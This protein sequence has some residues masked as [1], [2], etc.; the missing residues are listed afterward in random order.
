[1]NI[2]P[3][4]SVIITTHN[5]L[6]FLKRA[7]LSVLNQTY[8]NIELIISDDCS[9]FDLTD[10]INELKLKSRFPIIYRRNNYNSG[11]CHTR[12]EGI[13]LSTGEFITG[14]DDDEFVP[15]RVEYLVSNY[16]D[17]FS[18]VA[19]NTRVVTKKSTFS[20]FTEKTNKVISYNDLLW[21]NVIGTQ[22]LVNRERILFCNGFD[23][24][25][26]SGQDADMWLTLTK[27][28]G[29]ALRL[30]SCKYILHTEHDNLRITTSSKKLDGWLQVYD[31]YKKDRTNSQL[32]YQIIKIEHYDNRLLLIF[33]LIISFNFNIYRFLLKR[34]FNNL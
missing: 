13:K 33:H 24:K 3:K 20:M 32:K 15:D 14:L 17:R 2:N 6:D 25:L 21:E 31:K 22:V 16:S 10:L 23:T 30:K 11:A 18:F 8:D 7:M 28:Y 9:D 34:F 5:R 27:L 4:V 12:N 19:T 1:M 29:P 26:S